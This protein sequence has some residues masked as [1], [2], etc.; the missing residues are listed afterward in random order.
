LAS[1]TIVSFVLSML[2]AGDRKQAFGLPKGSMQALI[3]LSLIVIFAI[4]SAFLYGRLG[5]DTA[6]EDQTRFAQPS[7]SLNNLIKSI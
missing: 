5:V 2:N 4:M 3:A 7:D 6:T 1:L